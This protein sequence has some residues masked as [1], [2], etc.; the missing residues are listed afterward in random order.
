MIVPSIDLQDGNAVQ[1]VG[2]EE[3][4]IDAG[5]PEPIMERFRLAG[6]VALI[7]LDAA[8]GEGSNV[9]TLERL[10]QMGRCRVGGGIRDAETAREWLDRGADRVILGTAARSEILD[11]LPSDRVVAA[12]DA[13]DGEV[14][15]EG[16]TEPTG[17]G[18][19][20]R[21]RE[22]R[23]YVGAFMVTFV[24]REGRLEGTRLDAVDRLVEA[25]GEA[26]LTVAGGIATTDEIAELHRR[27][28]DAQVGMALYED[29]LHLADAIAAPLESDREDGL[30]PTVVCDRRGRAL[31]LAYS[32]HESLREA[33]DRGRGVYHSRERGLW[34]KGES[35][36]NVQHLRHVDLDC[37][38][39]T[40]RFVVEQQGEGFCHEDTWTC[41]GEDRGLGRLE[42]I[43]R[44]RA[45]RAPEGSYTRKLLEDPDLLRNKLL[46]EAGELAEADSTEDVVWEAADLLYFAMVAAVR[47]DASLESIEAEL[48]RRMEPDER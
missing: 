7:D 3:L 28:V 11:Q 37:D 31:G 35:S 12:L 5:D 10:V 33:V 47:G 27:G 14:V 32:D 24:E 38:A 8:M 44:D 40:L 20:E 25:S 29:R 48:T 13:V 41:W 26:D 30:W 21:M 43:L 1:L 2:G 22:L 34:V 19:V 4:A 23:E 15:V 39:D 42:R 45:E 16:W 6:E 46:E 17:E 9:E 36:G 18:V